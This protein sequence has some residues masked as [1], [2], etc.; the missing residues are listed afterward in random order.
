MNQN[1]Y[2]YFRGRQFELLALREMVLGNLLSDAI[3]PIVEPVKLSSALLTTFRAFNGKKHLI[4]LV[5]NP[6]FGDVVKSLSGLD[7]NE[8]LVYMKEFQA[9]NVRQVVLQNRSLPGAVKLFKKQIL[10]HPDRWISLFASP[11]FLEVSQKF[12]E[13]GVVYGINLIPDSTKF[14]RGVTGDKVLFHD[15]FVKQ[16]RN[17]DYKQS[18]NEFFSDD[19]VFADEEGYVGTGDFSI[20]G[21]EYSDSGFAPYA[22]AIHIVYEDDKKPGTLR[23][24]H[25]VS[26]SNDGHDDPAG[27]FFEAAGKLAKWAK[28]SSVYRSVGL[29]RIIDAYESEQYPGLGSLK[30]FSIMHHLELMGSVLSR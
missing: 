23:V 27:K 3:I 4:G 28:G 6:E 18:P 15:C 14:R 16:D 9:L 13:E 30:K 11:E 1:Y 7:G 2:P 26:D 24:A 5:R 17:A 25:F 19:H 10:A 21:D 22:V 8:Q 29:K 20:I 12:A